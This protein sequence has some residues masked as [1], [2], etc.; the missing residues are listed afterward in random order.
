VAPEPVLN[1]MPL[2]GFRRRNARERSAGRLPDFVVIG[3]AKSGSTTLFRWLGQHPE[4]GLPRMKEPNFFSH[5]HVWRRGAAWYRRQFLDVAPELRTGEASVSCTDPMLTEAASERL[6]RII[7]AARLVCVVRHPVER[8]RS[9]YRHQV[10]RGR[11]HRPFLDAVAGNGSDYVERSRYATCLRPWV[12]RFGTDQ[13]LVIR[14]E[15]LVGDDGSTWR[16][17]LSHLAVSPLPRPEGAFNVTAG[18]RQFTRPMR[19]LW[20]AGLLPT[21]GRVPQPVRRIARAVL[22]KDG[23]RYAQRIAGSGQPLPSEL[24]DAMWK[25]VERLPALMGDPRLRWSR[26]D[27]E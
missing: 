19:L 6:A 23:R 1:R 18:K 16:R 13:L 22:L 8:L 15:D 9:H 17:L 20:E 25:D 21:R 14:L 27:P 11:E 4:I 7:P 2:P 12:E 24:V 3:T 5:D 10:Q 26:G